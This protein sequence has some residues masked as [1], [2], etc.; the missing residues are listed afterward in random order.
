MNQKPVNNPSFSPSK[1]PV[2]IPPAKRPGQIPPLY[3]PPA[4]P[5]Y[6]FAPDHGQTDPNL[7]PQTPPS[8]AP[9]EK[10]PMPPTGG[11]GSQSAP[12]SSPG[13]LGS[14]PAPSSGAAV[15][16][17]QTPPATAGTSPQGGT[18]ASANTSSPK[19]YLPLPR[20]MRPEYQHLAQKSLTGKGSMA[21]LFSILFCMFFTELILWGNLGVSALILAILY[22]PFCLW[23]FHDKEKPV[24]PV[25]WLLGLPVA[26]IVLGLGLSVN[27]STYFITVPVLLALAAAQT[28]LLGGL[29]CRS[30]FSW[31]GFCAL[32]GRLID[33]PLAFLDFPFL[34]MGGRLRS[35]KRSKNFWKVFLGF[36][37]ALPVVILLLYLFASADA[38]FRAGLQTFFRWLRLDWAHLFTDLLLGF[39]GGV[40]LA[41]ILLY[42]RGALPSKT[43][44]VNCKRFL[45]PLFAIPFL[46]LID[47]SVLAF[48]LV[49]F[50]YLFGGQ[51]GNL[52]GGYTYAEYARQ[53]FFELAFSLFLIFAI[54]LF[55]MAFCKSDHPGLFLAIRL[56]LLLLSLG[57]GVILVSAVKRMLLYVGV[58]GL[59]VKRALTLWFMVTA[60]IC[61]LL[62]AA[63][64]LLRR[65]P[66]AKCTGVFVTLMVCLL[67]LFP[68]DGFVARYNVNAYLSGQVEAEV[69]CRYLKDLSVSALPAMV[70][71]YQHQPSDELARAINR[72]IYVNERRHPIWG[73]TA[74]QPAIQKSIRQFKAAVGEQQ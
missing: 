59:S 58:Y 29:S 12:V 20:K 24:S 50:A 6:P 46:G 73:W 11:P 68:V 34:V 2:Y 19:Y 65:F 40:F 17:G 22:Y 62:L 27:R 55:A 18:S 43:R 15:A 74:D 69:D 72:Q 60:G 47:L 37:C 66:L 32:W 57:G 23:Y 53:G 16:N 14:R 38:V 4:G 67:S 52:P 7:P 70:D 30:L 13:G 56:E 41:A 8:P 61:F 44:P 45:D 28:A 63:R 10:S 31:E 36:L 5:A 49:Q 3:Q 35:G 39:F 42:C 1:P 33:G 71:L 51:K 54:A 26:A 48:T 25:A 64:C 9:K 21:V